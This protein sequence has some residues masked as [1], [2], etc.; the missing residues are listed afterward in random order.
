MAKSRL[1]KCFRGKARDTVQSMLILADNLDEIMEALEFSF[2]QPDQ[3]IETMIE[4]IK[5]IPNLREAKSEMFIE[6]HM[7]GQ[8]GCGKQFEAHIPY[9][10]ITC[11]DHR[12]FICISIV[13]RGVSCLS[14]IL[15][16]TDGRLW[17]F[18]VGSSQASSILSQN[19]FVNA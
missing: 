9:Y 14:A 15:I 11:R 19:L 8:S 13:Q 12:G 10:L 4:N 7:H 2:G 1:R 17:F 18:K 6:R 16:F 3:I 5:R